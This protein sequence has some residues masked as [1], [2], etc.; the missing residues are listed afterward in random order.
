MKLIISGSSSKGN[1]YA[2]Q[3]D[4]GEILLIE[5]GIHLR[6]VKKAIGYKTSKVVGCI[7]SHAHGDHSKY[8]PEYLKA[9]IN[10]SSND[11]VAE[12]Y[13]G[14]DTM[15]ENITFRFGN[16]GVTP[17]EVEH[18]AKNFGYLIHEPSYGTILFAT[19]CYNLHFYLKGCKT[20]LAECNYSDTILDKAVADGKT[21][22]SQADRV[23]LSHMSLEHSIAWLKE[24]DAE[25]CAHQIILIHGSARHLNPIIAVKKFQQVIGVPTYY[26]KS[27]KIINLI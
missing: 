17:F 2:L 22:R 20:Y 23:R 3:S 13:P 24:C 27:G 10:V 9:G 15:Y 25:H 8:I 6:E 26:A 18:D 16:F 21:P 5:A 4:S 7:V 11:E 1:S 12:K 19:D 14:V